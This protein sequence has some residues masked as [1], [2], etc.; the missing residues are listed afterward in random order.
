MSNYICSGCG[1][2]LGQNEF[3]QFKDCIAIL[4]A[5]KKII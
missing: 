5:D 2:E 3:H 1:A 4:E